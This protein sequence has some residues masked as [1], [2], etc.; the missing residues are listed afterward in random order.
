MVMASS[1][2]VAVIVMMSTFCKLN[3]KAESVRIPLVENIKEEKSETIAENNRF[4]E[5]AAMKTLAFV[6][7][8]IKAKKKA[9]REHIKTEQ[10]IPKK[11]E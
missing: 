2:K 8:T 1:K 7:W 6:L 5:I 4:I 9:M 3:E 11:N 10:K